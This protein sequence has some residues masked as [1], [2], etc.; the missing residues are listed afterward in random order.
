LLTTLPI[1]Y[2]S[3]FI[4]ETLNYRG[5][6]KGHRNWVTSIATTEDSNKIVTG[7]RDKTVLVWALGSQDDGSLGEPKRSLKGHSHFVSD[8]TISSDGNFCLSSSWDSTLRLWDLETGQTTRQF[9][10][11]KKDALSVAFSPDNR[12][13]VSGSRDRSIKLWNTIGECKMTVEDAHSDWVSCVRFSPNMENPIIV[14]AGWDKVVKVYSLSNL[15]A[16]TPLVGHTGY[17]NTVTVSPDGSLCASGGKDGTANL[18][19]LNEGKRLYSLETKGAII[20]A[21]CFSP[22]K[23]WLCAA[24]SQNI[25]IWDLESKN[26]VCELKPEEE[27]A[28]GHKALIPF[29][30]CLSWSMDG[31]TLYAGYTNG[32]VRVWHVSHGM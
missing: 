30:T 28:R 11:H 20:H 16:M 4:T 29:P 9:T 25:T 10:G 14:S 32:L 17:L 2:L 6:L 26:I 7:S 13:I 27:E 21:L 22:N 12:Q 15:K 1:H 24:T 31:T 3:L 18:W 5:E 19:D 23:Y 8:V